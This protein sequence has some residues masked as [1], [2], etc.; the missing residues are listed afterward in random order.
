MLK[1]T[2]A[3]MMAV[4]LLGLSSQSFAATTLA[5]IKADA[6]GDGQQMT[7]ELSGERMTAG[8]GYYEKLMLMLKNADGKMVTAWKPD[9]DGGYHGFLQK[10]PSGEEGRDDILLLVSQGGENPGLTARIL[11]FK[12]PKKVQEEFS[13]ADSLGI[14]STAEYMD[15]YKA[16]V[17]CHVPVFEDTSLDPA[18]LRK[19]IVEVLLG[20]GELK[21]PEDKAT[22]KEVEFTMEAQNVLGVYDKDG[23]VVKPYLKPRV[24]GLISLVKHNGMLYSVQNVLSADLQTVL[25]QLSATWEKHDGRWHP[26]SVQLRNDDLAKNIMDKGAGMNS[27]EGAGDWRLFPQTI[28]QGE[29]Q[30]SYPLVSVDGKPELQNKIND[31]LRET[32]KERKLDESVT[33]NVEF[34]GKRLLSLS[35]YRVD[36]EG[37]EV[38]ADVYNVDMKTGKD[39]P[40][41]K[42]FDTRNKDFVAA[43]NLVGTPRNAFTRVKPDTWFYDGEHFHFRGDEKKDARLAGKD[44]SGK[45]K[46]VLEEQSETE[47]KTDAVKPAEVATE[48][49][50][51]EKS[52]ETGTE[53]AAEQ[54]EATAEN[55][56]APAADKS[57]EPAGTE[58]P[59]KS[60]AVRE[61]KE[62][63]KDTAAETTESKKDTDK[64]EAVKED[65]DSKNGKD[66][67]KD[68]NGKKDGERKKF[69]A[70]KASATAAEEVTSAVPELDPEE[71]LTVRELMA[72]EKAVIFDNGGIALVKQDA[73][74]D[75]VTK[76][77]K[78]GSKEKKNRAE[79]EEAVDKAVADQI[80]EETGKKV[81]RVVSLGKTEPGTAETP[82]TM[83]KADDLMAFLKDRTLL[84][85]GAEDMPAAL[86]ELEADDKKD[87]VKKESTG[88][89][90]EKKAGSG[91]ADAG[92]DAAEED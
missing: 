81:S 4:L 14:T 3:G 16:K 1:K 10:V 51:A 77:V 25:G 37:E 9:M 18:L 35:L 44:I 13:S 23:K 83:V 20:T 2:V 29:T 19:S 34:A 58:A 66:A 41:D 73:L 79:V 40:M 92:K 74:N 21:L 86:A 80:A 26:V 56:A 45:K 76:E 17:T 11:D 84:E 30:I 55:T 91:K 22:L 78:A 64:G 52:A 33:Y 57:V 38:A 67:Q 7:V 63:S 43:L 15:D 72:G 32:A 68:K 90:G 12:D 42:M 54:A 87:G 88:K 75:I 60:E 6:L 89:D 27:V 48:A 85:K 46:A 28:W 62:E 31:L 82:E 24:T 50:T 49:T 8:S 69:K 53:F 59:V 71:A 39:I 5:E 36:P 70:V 61:T 65:K 47:S